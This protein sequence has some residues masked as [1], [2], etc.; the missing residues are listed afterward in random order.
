MSKVLFFPAEHHSQDWDYW[1][2]RIFTTDDGQ[3]AYL[4]QRA[5]ERTTTLEQEKREMAA[6]IRENLPPGEEQA[7]AR[8]GL[9]EAGE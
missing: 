7:L 1:A 5:R 4:A 6:W 8:L 3:V 2:R 9:E